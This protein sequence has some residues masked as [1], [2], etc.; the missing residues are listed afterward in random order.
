MQVRHILCAVDLSSRT[1]DIVA[2]ATQL[3]AFHQAALTFVHV[4]PSA[5]R[6]G[7]AGRG[8]GGLGSGA[9]SVS[10]INANE[11]RETRARE[12]MR[13]WAQDARAQT[14]EQVSIEIAG[15]DAATEII[16]LSTSGE[17]DLLVLGDH[18]RAGLLKSLLGSVSYKVVRNAGCSVLLVRPQA[19]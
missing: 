3:A 17:Y 16:N 11:E 18:G 19:A 15:G 1:T 12:A 10:D 2:A 4:L 13:Q 14:P 5:P 9:Y 8:M 6:S 7:T